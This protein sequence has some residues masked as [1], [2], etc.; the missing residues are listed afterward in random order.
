MP[1][2]VKFDPNVTSMQAAVIPDATTRNDGVMTKAQAAQLIGARASAGLLWRHGTSSWAEK[3]AQARAAVAAGNYVTI[4]LDGKPSDQFD[5][6]GDADLSDITIA[7]ARASQVFVNFAADFRLLTPNITMVRISGSTNGTWWTSNL[8]TPESLTWSL[9]GCSIAPIPGAPNIAVV[10]GNS[11]L[12]LLFEESYLQGDNPPGHTA[13]AVRDG[14]S[15]TTFCYS[16]SNYD[17]TMVELA[18]GSVGPIDWYNFYD[19]TD[20]DSTAVYPI[21]AGVTYHPQPTGNAAQL[22]YVPTAGLFA[23]PQPT[24]TADA[25]NRMAAVVKTLNAG[26]PIP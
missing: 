23:D 19:A 17:G 2:T 11:N 22:N 18:A 9:Y 14:G 3:Y 1:I 20:Q 16:Q 12:V 13:F 5:I 7:S 6:G 8:A 24:S 10:G 26:N 15:L 4:W 25:M 21:L